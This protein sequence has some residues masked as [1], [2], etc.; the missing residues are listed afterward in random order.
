M[1]DKLNWGIL[2]NALIARKCVIP[3]IAASRNGRIGALA[4]SRPAAAED[5]VKTFTIEQLYGRY[6][7]VI[8]DPSID[9]VYVPL[10]NHLHAFWSAEAL[11]AGKH[12]LC[13]KPL[14][15][16]AEEARQMAQAASDNN[17]ILMEAQMY[18]FH[19]RTKRVSAMIDEGYI[20]EPL[21]V[22]ASFC[23]SMD[24]EL[25]E[26]GSN[27]RLSSLPGGG[28]LMDVGCYGVGIARLFLQKEPVSVQAQS[29]FYPGSEV[30][31][32]LV[33][34]LRFETNALA[35]VE[36]SF[37]AGLQQTYSITGNRG[38]I[39]LPHNAFIPWNNDALIYYRAH[40]EEEPE[41]IVVPGVDQYQ[42]MIE[43]FGD[44]VVDGVG[45]QISL[46]DSVNNMA[47]LDAL[48]EAARSGGRV[49]VQRYNLENG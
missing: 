33:G 14:A 4:T 47:V 8:G 26:N 29:V 44:Q 9:A 30:D 15:C 27:Y 23:F 3:A 7:D 42:A 22:R 48:A 24:D 13:E 32:H 18:R 35:T 6:E 2:G 12:V 38:V 43:H 49:N 34:N 16:T 46:N 11:S 17:R 45:S 21:L 36:A 37:C 41:R 39:E 25:L 5:L 40:E 1:K 31:I 28:A 19:P 10:P 20:G